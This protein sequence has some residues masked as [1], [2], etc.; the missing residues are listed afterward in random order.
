[1]RLV[2]LILLLFPGAAVADP[3]TLIAVTSAL[4]ST[5]FTIGTIAVSWGSVIFTAGSLL[6][7]AAAQRKQKKAAASAA[8]AQRDS[9]N[10]GLNDRTISGVA[11][12]FPR[13]FVYGTAR[14]GANIVA[15]FTSGARDEN[16]HLVGVLAQ[17]G[18]EAILE[19]YL[20]GQPLGALDGNG[21]PISGAF[22]TTSTESRTVHSVSTVFSI[23]DEPDSGTLRVF[24]NP[25]PDS[26]PPAGGLSN[27]SKSGLAIT[28]ED[29][30]INPADPA[31][32]AKLDPPYHATYQKTVSIPMVRI[33]KHLGT[34]TDPADPRLMA[35]VPGKWPA[36][37]VLRGHTYGVL[38]LNLN[39]PEF[40]GGPPQWENLVQGRKLYDPRTGLTVWSENPALVLYDYLISDMGGVKASSIPLASFI[41][42]ANVCDE[43]VS[44]GSWSGKRYTFNGVITSDQ[45][46]EDVLEKI[47]QSMAGGIDATT[48]TVFAGKYTAPVMALSQEDIVGEIAISP[49]LPQGDIFNTVKGQ[50]ISAENGYVATDYQPYQ[51]AAYLAVDGEELDTNVD[52]PYTNSQQ[53]ATNLCRI[54][55]ESNR[56]GY[57]VMG[58]FS[59]KTWKL[60]VG[61]R[62]TLAAPFFFG[63]LEKVFRITDKAFAPD[64]MV[65]LGLKEDAESIYDLADETRPDATPNTGLPNPFVV[66]RLGSLTCQSGDAQL[67]IQKSGDIVSRILA[68][69]PQSTTQGVLQK[70]YIEVEFQETTQTEWQKVE[71]DGFETAAFLSPVE[72][73]KYYNVR[74]R[75]VNPYVT[76]KGDWVYAATHRV[77]GKT[78]PP[79]DVITFTVLG[80]SFTWGPVIALDLAG[81]EIRFNFGQNTAWG[82]GTPL[83]TG[84][85]TES[86]W[87]P[88]VYPSGPITVMV[89]AIDTSGNESANAA[90]IQTNLGDPIVANL[91]E[92][93]DDKAAGFQGMKV[94]G[95]VSGGDLLA[96]DSGDLFWGADGANFWGPDG[97][98]F[99]PASTYKQMTY[100]VSYT[101][102]ANEIGSRLTLLTEIEGESYTIEYRFGTQG[103]FWGP[104]GNFFWGPDSAPFWPAPTA[105]QTWP[106]AIDALQPGLIEIRISTQP[107]S[108]RGAIRELTFQFD[109]EDETEFINDVAIS[110]IG[111]RLP[112]TKVYREIK[113]V[114]LTLQAAPGG[115]DHAETADKLAT[116]P[117]VYTKNGASLTTGVVDA[118]IQGVKGK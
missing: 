63:D 1:M 64:K 22:I 57:T 14:V 106:G 56:N 84:L 76:A 108:V 29:T 28:I 88:L 4:S 77:I 95:T 71:V 13:R 26:F 54:F 7:G 113:N 70:G 115:A 62:V 35:E 45:S 23:P 5:A 98:F 32:Y 117:L 25:P 102:A 116:G 99:W 51:N 81:Y 73:G 107:G 66:D 65:Q 19:T 55:T 105:W 75:G 38:L 53:R 30:L 86:P 90:S 46:R 91:I 52:L 92:V 89:K 111:T 74:A 49:G 87:T 20:N 61:D 83:H 72:D 118:F 96:D 58:R 42:A 69:W 80:Q 100:T 78:D 85:V 114:Q 110:A 43:I 21:S 68:T 50:F 109:V 101:V 8:Q 31:Y 59:L 10:A 41:A 37:A 44:T 104:A 112:L 3:A 67:L 33:S 39:Q 40:Q 11:T 9:F 47:A 18:S 93:Y 6:Y 48:W 17:G 16:K 15:I 27:F 12:E 60:Q 103:L 24:G 79:P 36:T 94:N 82:T 2:L 34:P 97:A